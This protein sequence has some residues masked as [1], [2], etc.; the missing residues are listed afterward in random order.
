[1]CRSSCTLPQVRPELRSTHRC[2]LLCSTV[3]RKPGKR[4][5]MP[6]PEP[7]STT[8]A[9][10]GCA[11][12][13][14]SKANRWQSPCG[15]GQ[16]SSG[17][18]LTRCGGRQVLAERNGT[19]GRRGVDRRLRLAHYRA[20]GQECCRV[21]M[22]RSD[23]PECVWDGAP[24]ADELRERLVALL[25]PMVGDE[26]VVMLT[27]D[28]LLAGDYDAT[29]T[30]RPFVVRVTDEGESVEPVEARIAAWLATP[31]PSLDGDRPEVLLRGDPSS[32]RRLDYV[33]AEMEQGAFS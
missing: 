24:S 5:T 4:W 7:R 9:P 19:A 32:R 13:L 14:S 25:S 31:N 17:G 28:Q 33:I 2:R 30:D 12:A 29:V 3:G 22:N 15:A 18:G 21:A 20:I 8:G 1:M 10:S 6:Y 11:Q 16:K 26:D 27:K 23:G